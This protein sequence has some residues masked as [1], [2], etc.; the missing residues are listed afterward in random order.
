MLAER[1]E[2]LPLIELFEYFARH[3]QRVTEL[4]R[5]SLDARGGVHR[6]ADHRVLVPVVR[7]YVPHH[8]LAHVQA[9][10]DRDRLEALAAE[11]AIQ[12]LEAREHLARGSDGAMRGSRERLRRAEEAHHAVADELVD[13]A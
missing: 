11:G 12:P 5:Q 9:D 2:V 10:A 7:S 4:L 8:H 3:D 6:I 1:R 13:R